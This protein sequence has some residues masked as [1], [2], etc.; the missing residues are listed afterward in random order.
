MVS[1]KL[2]LSIFIFVQVYTF[3]FPSMKVYPHTK[4]TGFMQTRI[5]FTHFEIYKDL[6]PNY[7]QLASEQKNYYL[8]CHESNHFR[9]LIAE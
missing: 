7:S 2:K 9:K 5:I 8:T 6:F 1:I 3:E 4:I